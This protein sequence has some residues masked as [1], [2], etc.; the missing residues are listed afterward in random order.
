VGKFHVESELDFPAFYGDEAER[1]D[2]L[3]QFYRQWRDETLVVNQWFQ[4]QA[5]LP[6]G[7][8]LARVRGLMQHPDFDLR[9]PNKVRAVV[10]GFSAGN[11][12]GFHRA[13]GAGYRLLVGQILQLDQ[14]NPQ[15]AARMAGPLTRWKRFEP[16]RRE[17]MKAELQRLQATEL[18]RDLY[19]IVTKSLHEEK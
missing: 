12:V 17:L 1:S 16:R 4:L 18:S 14:K 8:A 6:H 15:V 11:P 2:A 19:E 5:R 13:D 7:D 3:A 9:N 10:G